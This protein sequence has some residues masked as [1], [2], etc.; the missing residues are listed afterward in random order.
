M[1]S[2]FSLVE[3]LIVAG[4]IGLATLASPVKSI[5]QVPGVYTVLQ[6]AVF[7]QNTVNV[8][9]LGTNSYVNGI[10]GSGS[11]LTFNCSGYE[12][13]GLALTMTAPT[14][15]TNG[16]VGILVYRSMNNGASF[17]QNPYWTF[18]F[19]NGSPGNTTNYLTTNLVTT[20]CTTLGFVTT[21]ATGCYETNIMLTANLQAKTTQYLPANV[22][23]GTSPGRPIAVPNFP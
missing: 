2:K 8:Y 21:N 17:D 9:N 16:A 10:P 5:G 12:N 13:V 23:A 4:L 11:N 15:A 20:S 7:P 19:N 18:T 3:K 1:K 6:S 14:A 22:N